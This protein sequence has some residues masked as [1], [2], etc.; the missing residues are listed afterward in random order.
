MSRAKLLAFCRRLPH[1]T[2]DVKWKKDLVFSVGD[3]MFACLNAEKG[4]AISFK[5]DP[6]TFA[7]LTQ[8]PGIVPAPYAAR[9]YWVLVTSS[10]SLPL[11][12]L[13]E[14]IRESH[15]LVV[16]KLPAKTRRKL[17]LDNSTNR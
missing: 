7:R 8:Q 1:A 4:D 11:G 3:K 17:K 5:T 14:L 2:E 10:K 9:F 16:E 6:A 15:R 12:M 13:Q